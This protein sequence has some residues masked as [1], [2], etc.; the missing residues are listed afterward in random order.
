[1]R[2]IFS[3]SHT[4]TL[5]KYFLALHKLRAGDVVCFPFVFYEGCLIFFTDVFVVVVV[6]L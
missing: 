1:M 3:G 6:F 4:E 2:N 5:Q